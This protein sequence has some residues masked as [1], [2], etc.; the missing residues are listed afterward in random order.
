MI[1]ITIIL[2]TMNVK[3]TLI[4]LALVIPLLTAASLW[5]RPASGAGYDRVRDGIANVLGDLSESLHGMRTIAAYNRQRWNIVQHRNVVGDYRD[6][7]NYTA[8]I[9]AVYG[10]GTQMLGY[11]GQA[12][13]LAIGGHMV[14]DHQLIDR[15]ARRVLPVP[16][17]LLRADPAAGPAVQHL[18]A[19]PGLGLQA[20]D[21]VRDRAHAAEA[22]DAVELPPVRGR[23]RLR[24]RDLRLRPGRHRSSAT[25]TCGSR[26]A[27]P[28][29]SSARRGRASRPLA[30]LITRFYDPTRGAS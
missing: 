2:F 21:P 27:R 1:V 5:F 19:G 3:L 10:P 4:T 9:N 8:Q 20:A 24:P 18:P 17:P 30:K 11:L 7:N 15:R 29:P 6:A 28:S 22:A 26:P 14:L 12:A 25:S 23:D 13:L 16:E